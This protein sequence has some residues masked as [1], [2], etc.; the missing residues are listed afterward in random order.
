MRYKEKEER[1]APTHL[2]F[3]PTEETTTLNSLDLGEKAWSTTSK[4]CQP[5]RTQ[6]SKST[7]GRRIGT[8]SQ[9]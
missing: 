9:T 7:K 2:L 1:I 3:A 8:T 4:D 6:R 5:K